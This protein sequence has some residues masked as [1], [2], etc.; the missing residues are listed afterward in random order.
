MPHLRVPVPVE[1]M[2]DLDATSPLVAHI[3]YWNNP[4]LRRVLYS[5]LTTR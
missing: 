3:Q 2:E 5:V 1:N 4:T